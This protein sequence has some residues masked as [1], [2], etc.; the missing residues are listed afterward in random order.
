[1]K[2][3]LILLLFSLQAIACY[4]GPIYISFFGITLPQMT[5]KVIM[6]AQLQIQNNFYPAIKEVNKAIEQQNKEIKKLI[7]AEIQ[8]GLALEQ[9]NFEIDK[10]LKIHSLIN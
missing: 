2:K 7:E 4:C 1:M 5:N 3:V 8:K 10:A 9:L 6:S